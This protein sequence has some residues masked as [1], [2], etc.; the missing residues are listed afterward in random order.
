MFDPGRYMKS[1]LARPSLH[2]YDRK[3]LRRYWG[4][5]SVTNVEYGTSVLSLHFSLPFGGLIRGEAEVSVL[6]EGDADVRI[7]V[8]FRQC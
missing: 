6:L 2:V 5:C 4:R 8:T 3:M 7:F 1:V